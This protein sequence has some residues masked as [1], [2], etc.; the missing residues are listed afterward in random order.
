MQRGKGIT[1]SKVLPLVEHW[2]WPKGEK[3]GPHG[4]EKKAER[5]LKQ[6]TVPVLGPV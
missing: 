3:A 2:E 6:A 1:L 5:T 4:E